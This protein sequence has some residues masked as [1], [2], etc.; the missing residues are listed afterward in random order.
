MYVTEHTVQNHPKPV[1]AKTRRSGRRDLL[2]RA[3]GACVTPG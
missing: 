2:T 3:L 1:F